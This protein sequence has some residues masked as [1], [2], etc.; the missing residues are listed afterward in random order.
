MSRADMSLPIVKPTSFRLSEIDER[1]LGFGD[2][3]LA[4]EADADRLARTGDAARSRLEKELRSVGRVDLV[5][6]GGTR[7]RFVHAGHLAALV[8]HAGR[9][10]FLLID[11]RQQSHLVERN[12]FGLGI[13][14]KAG[15]PQRLGRVQNI[16]ERLQLVDLRQIEQTQTAIVVCDGGNPRL[17]VGQSNLGEFHQHHSP[18]F[19]RA[20]VAE[21]STSQD[22]IARSPPAFGGCRP[23]MVPQTRPA[24]HSAGGERRV[25]R[26][27]APGGRSKRRRPR[28]VGA[29]DFCRGG[30]R[31]GGSAVSGS[32]I[33]KRQRRSAAVQTVGDDRMAQVLHVDPQLVRS[34]GFRKEPHRP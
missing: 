33:R 3:P 26:R 14:E 25:E 2:G 17:S 27:A 5:V 12:R 7:F 6:V 31:I 10:H 9:P 29:V 28:L 8:G 24:F 19:R 4:V 30:S 18:S 13:D 20:N 23:V 34:S 32:E 15:Q 1:Q 21:P 11:R 16:G 22:N